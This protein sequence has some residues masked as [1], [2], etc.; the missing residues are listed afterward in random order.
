MPAGTA[1]VLNKC[2]N[3]HVFTIK[4]KTD[5]EPYN[6]KSHC[7]RKK[8]NAHIKE[9]VQRIFIHSTSSHGFSYGI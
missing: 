4:V 7:R 6:K 9:T 5:K 1:H 2:N 8:Y 3:V